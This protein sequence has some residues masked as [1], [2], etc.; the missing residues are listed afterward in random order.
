MLEFIKSF[1]AERKITL[2]SSLLL[3][4]CTIKRSYLL[5]R[6][7]IDDGSVVIF[8]VPYLSKRINNVQN[9]S[10][11]A[12]SRD[13]HI[14]FASLFGELLSELMGRYP[15][16]KFVG[17]TDHSPIDEIEAAAKAGLGVIG[18]NHLLITKEHSSY[19]FIAELI[20]DALLPS[21]ATQ[22]EACM[23]CG[24][25]LDA[26]PSGLSIDNCLSSI[27][28]KKGELTNDEIQAIADS[29]CAWGCDRCQQVCP[30]TK[31]AMEKRSIY[32]D[33][34]FFNSDLTPFLTSEL[35]EK[36]ADEEFA[37]R[38]YSW[39]G[40][41]VIKRNLKILEAKEKDE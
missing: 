16:N 31:I 15:E 33:I 19:V 11:Y 38:A 24:K 9:V 36:M 41:D 13:Y 21:Y 10:S 37:L 20:T 3:K 8:A 34:D 35:I 30:Y 23:G 28:Q 7:G 12:V 25:C 39:R 29:G 26:C 18:N 32:T 1:L 22:I 17:F 14:Y 6:N 40:K 2:V 4:E 27:T 5:T